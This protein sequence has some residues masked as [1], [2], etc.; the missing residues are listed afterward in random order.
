MIK[1]ELNENGAKQ[2]RNS[3]E[4][5]LTEGPPSLEMWNEMKW[6]EM[7]MNEWNSV[8]WTPKTEQFEN[9]N[10]RSLEGLVVRKRKT[11]SFLRNSVNTNWYI[12]VSVWKRSSVNR[13]ENSSV[14]GS[15]NGSKWKRSNV[16]PGSVSRDVPHSLM[17]GTVLKMWEGGCAV[18]NSYGPRPWPRHCVYEIIKKD[19]TN[20]GCKR[21]SQTAQLTH[22][23]HLILFMEIYIKL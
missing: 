10:I 22:T 7:K 3:W 19:K 15:K 11:D 13:E 5:V 2:K 21:S 16:S 14:F 9:A 8:V 6:N 12:S 17:D 18:G 23:L 20:N 4:S 1:T